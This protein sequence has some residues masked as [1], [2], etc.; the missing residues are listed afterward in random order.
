MGKIA[1]GAG[2]VVVIFIYGGAVAL[3]GDTLVKPAV[4]W[5]IG[6]AGSLLTWV[7]LRKIWE[8]LIPSS[9]ILRILTHVV[10]TTGI[11]SFAFLALNNYCA[12]EEE[13]THHAAITDTYR[14][15]RHHRQRVGRNRWRE[16]SPYYVYFANLRFDNGKEK[17]ISITPSQ[18]TEFKKRKTLDITLHE[19]VFGFP[20]IDR[21]KP[22][23]EKERKK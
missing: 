17:K 3:L 12:S 22:P 5:V 6:I 9:L 8:T 21:H 13:T 19:G 10:V 15:T 4:P 16:G 2:C 18:Y 14:E 23:F 1:L 20:V 7:G 11:F